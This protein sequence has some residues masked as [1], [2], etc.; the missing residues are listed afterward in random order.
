M[1]VTKR[2]VF[3]KVILVGR[4]NEALPEPR[5]AVKLLAG[6]EMILKVAVVELAPAL[7]QPLKLEN[8][9]LEKV[10]LTAEGAGAGG[11]ITGTTRTVGVPLPVPFA[12]LAAAFEEASW[13]VLA[14]P[15]LQVFEVGE[16]TVPFPP[17]G[18]VL[19]T[20][21]RINISRSSLVML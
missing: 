6:P 7:I 11:A 9:R 17:P 5:L 21:W 10:R 2:L 8:T 4:E 3:A 20:I 19:T 15:G 12:A 14:A 16:Q 18:K 1:V 13:L